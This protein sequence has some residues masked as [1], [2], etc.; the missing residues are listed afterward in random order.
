M[1]NNKTTIKSIRRKALILLLLLVCGTA[2][3]RAQGVVTPEPGKLYM[4]ECLGRVT[5][6]EFGKSN[7]SAQGHEHPFW[8]RP[9]SDNN[10]STLKLYHSFSPSSIF[11][12]EDS[13]TEGIYYI[14]NWKTDYY[15]Q[16]TQG[17]R[18]K[19]SVTMVQTATPGDLHKYKFHKAVNDVTVNTGYNAT[20]TEYGIMPYLHLKTPI[21]L[22]GNNLACLNP[23]GR[24]QNDIGLYIYNSD[25]SQW[26]IYEVTFTE[27][28]AATEV[29]GESLI[30]KEGT[31]SYSAKDMPAYTSYELDGVTYRGTHNW[32]N[33]TDYGAEVPGTPITGG[34]WSLSA[35]AAGYAT[36]N[37]STGELTVSSLPSPYRVVRLTYTYSEGGATKTLSKDISIVGMATITSLNEITFADG[38]YRLASN[39][40]PTGTPQT[41]G[42]MEIGTEANP[43]RGTIDGQ[44]QTFSGWSNPLFRYVEDATIR[45]IIIGSADISTDG[46]AGAIAC[47]ADGASRIYNI[48]IRGGTVSGTGNVGGIV[49]KL[50]GTSRVINCYSYANITGGS[51]VGGIVGYNNYATSAALASHVRTMVMNCMMYGNITGGTH[52]YPVYGGL[53][54]TNGGNYG[55]NNYNF[56]RDE[57]DITITDLDHYNC[58]WPAEEEYLTRFDYFRSILNANR[59]LCAWWITGS[60]DNTDEVAKWV[61]A[62]QE[63]KYPILKPWGRYPS[64]INRDI[65]DQSL[66][67]RGTNPYEGRT[68]GTL[69]VSVQSAKGAS[70]SLQ[71]QI[72][73]MDSLHYDFGYYKVQLPYYNDVFGDPTSSDHATRYGGNYTSQ[74]VTGWEVVSVT[75]GTPG[76]FSTDRET[77]YNFADRHC[78]QK[79][80][81]SVSGRIFAQGGYY[82]VPEGV[83]AITIQA[84]W[85]KAYYCANTDYARDRTNFTISS[86]N[87][88]TSNACIPL[89]TIPTTFNGQP[90]YAGLAKAQEAIG[91]TGNTGVYDNAIVLVGNVQHLNANTNDLCV[92]GSAKGFTIMS[93]D[94][95]L[96]C[97]PDYVLPLQSGDYT[98]SK[99]FFSPIRFDF[100]QAPD[101]GMALKV[102]GT[103]NRLAIACIF[104]YGHFEITETSA[105][106]FN[107]I[108]FG[109]N[110]D[111][112][113]LAPFILNGGQTV[114][115]VCAADKGRANSTTPYSQDRTL[116]FIAGGNAKMRSFYQGNH[117]LYNLNVTHVPMNAIGGDFEECYLSGNLRSLKSNQVHADSPHLYTNGGRFGIIAGAGQESI[118]GDVFFR[119]DHSIIGEFYGG[120]TSAGGQIT[121]N[122]DVEINNSLVG[123]YCGGPMVGDMPEGKTVTTHAT[124]T[125]FRQFFGAGNGGTSFTMLGSRSSDLG[126]Q[127]PRYATD[128]SWQLT[129]NYE[130]M[131]WTSNSYEAKFHFEI[132]TIPSGTRATCAS[133]RYVYG[134]QFAATQ[135]GNVTSVLNRCTFLGDFYGGGNLGSVKGDAT[136]TLTDCTVY[137]NAYGAG[138]SA[139]IPSFDCYLTAGLEYPWQDLNTSICH[140]YT[141]KNFI[142]YTWTNEG[143]NGETFTRDGINYAHTN[144]SLANLGVV[145]GNAT[146]NIAGNTTVMGDV[147]GGGAL[148]SANTNNGKTATVNLTG[149]TIERN[150]YGGGQGDAKTAVTVGNTVVNLNQDVAN[151][152]VK[153]CVV[154]GSIF[155][156]NNINGTPQGDITVHIYKTQN[157][158]ASQ[159]VNSGEVNNAKQRGRYDVEA[160]YGGGN[161]AAYNPTTPWNGTTGSKSQVIIDGCEATSIG[162]VYGGG[163]AASVPET[164]VT[165]NGCY[166]VGWLFGGGNGAGEGN[167][168]ANVGLID[169]PS[170]N[171]TTVTTKPYGTG[172]A[173]TN[174]Q[175]GTV[176]HLF[177]GSNE[178]GNIVGIASMNLNEP[179]DC[180]V[181][182]T[183]PKNSSALVTQPPWTVTAI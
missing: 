177:G 1:T 40:T 25:C 151:T 46:D 164:N 77:G 35:N 52:V 162:Y 71:L 42:G 14:R 62:P 110:E 64:M 146:L 20:Y 38:N 67:D 81:Y 9:K 2:G 179:D 55:V 116:Y 54:I 85:A 160:V 47:V 133:R 173:N 106:H 102:D 182:S 130:P 109:N 32:C 24:N 118:D 147:Y 63:A 165:M 172:N 128:A 142:R 41:A 34:T 111:K 6:D 19:G 103:Q 83:T 123:F 97:E 76:T 43:F 86:G 145:L 3:V 114:E 138:F 148:A 166:E 84:H 124:G 104:L 60:T 99:R 122:I 100:V 170:D 70:E 153:G 112:K 115:F 163:N 127:N 82:Y 39:F 93:V 108:Y 27:V 31:Y 149:G 28:A 65:D 36:V 44:M 22:S 137:G 120:A 12:I 90:V 29:T 169:V 92:N 132:W 144:Y 74:V 50:D 87:R 126:A 79:D 21:N 23:D 4:F 176:G 30:K 8:L 78:T 183:S 69:S 158:A 161:Q 58:S 121:G 131:R 94:L 154:K 129:A 17:S 174:I 53:K 141:V 143:V 107:E 49:G 66:Y 33:N 175:G 89:G 18:T 167:P 51:T 95:D 96:D 125:T 98:A 26:G 5:Y 181:P 16:Y 59:E 171:A 135:T 180:D 155:G 113:Q 72:T 15:M 140:G 73:D 91:N 56:Y 88:V 101:L 178:R 117:N 75:G 45:N 57:A 7:T 119:I 10:N 80:I 61:Y 11:Y 134:A 13:D 136:S 68:M 150:V 139:T 152:G 48:G 37:A 105:M 168:G 159:I 156:G 157:T